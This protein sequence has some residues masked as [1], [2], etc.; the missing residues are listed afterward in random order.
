VCMP[1]FAGATEWLNSEPLGPRRA[2]GTRRP[3]QLLDADLHQLAAPGAVRACLVAGLPRRRAG[4]DRSAHARV[5]VRAG[6]RPCAAGDQGARDRLPGRARNEYEIWSA[7]D[8]HYWPA[9]YFVDQDGVIRDHHFGEARYEQ[10]ERVIQQ[11]LGVEREL[12]SVAGVGVEAEADWDTSGRLRRIS[13]TGAASDS[14]RRTA[15]RSTNDASMSSPSSC[16][17]TTG[18]SPTSGRSGARTSC[19]TER[20]EHR[21][22]LR[23]ARRASRGLSRSA[24]ADPVSRAPRRR[25]SGPLTRRRRR[26][27]RERRAPGRPPSTS[28][29]ASTTVSASGRWRSPSS[30]LAPTP[31]CSHS[32]RFTR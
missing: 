27:G 29:S 23:R 24:R 30:R 22:P 9:L 6:A 14:R 19:S 20:G 26:R 7:F 5:L 8:N 12:V 11:L 28:S 4:R 32:A 2:A 10:S 25:G 17:S 18:P 1:S 31:T 3:R 16:V 15:P 13:A 21:L